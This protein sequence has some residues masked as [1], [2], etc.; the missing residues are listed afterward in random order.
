MEKIDNYDSGRVES[1]R[2]QDGA[3]RCIAPCF[4]QGRQLVSAVPRTGPL[5]ASRAAWRRSIMALAGQPPR[6]PGVERDMLT[7]YKHAM[8]M[9][10]SRRRFNA[11]TAMS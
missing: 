9:W 5:P 6:A 8:R 11:V 4:Q 7:M 3:L 1:I 2:F 10:L